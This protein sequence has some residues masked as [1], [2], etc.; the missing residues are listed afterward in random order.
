[1]KIFEYERLHLGDRPKI[2]IESIEDKVK[3]LVMV[4]KR[5]RVMYIEDAKER[6][7]QVKKEQDTDDVPYP[8]VPSDSK[9]KAMNEGDKDIVGK[10]IGELD[11]P[12]W[13][14]SI[15]HSAN[16]KKEEYENELREQ[17]EAIFDAPSSEL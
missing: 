1:M 8:L 4:L 17:M 7:E 5:L 9:I 16:E 6:I 15:E 3:F 14:I 2:R 13:F 10:D 12:G 11:L